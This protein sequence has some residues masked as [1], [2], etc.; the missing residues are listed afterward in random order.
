MSKKFG[1]GS[2]GSISF[3]CP[4]TIGTVYEALELY[5]KEVDYCNRL[6]ELDKL[7]CK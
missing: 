6:Y 5:D 3:F 4:N 1:D 2:G 7:L